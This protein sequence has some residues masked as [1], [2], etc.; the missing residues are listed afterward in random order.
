[1]NT[2]DTDFLTNLFGR[3]RL[4]TRYSIHRQKVPK[5]TIVSLGRK[6]L[7]QEKGAKLTKLNWVGSYSFTHSRR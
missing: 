4:T 2:A 7:V 6:I 3:F 5:G 1:M